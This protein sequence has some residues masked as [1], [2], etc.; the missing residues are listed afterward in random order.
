DALGRRPHRVGR[1]VGGRA[2]RAARSA[3]RRILYGAT[4]GTLGATVGNDESKRHGEAALRTGRKSALAGGY[5]QKTNSSRRPAQLSV[6]C[7]TLPIATA[8]CTPRR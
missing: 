1:A 6:P 8:C 2:E 7:T 3:A 5:P 4:A